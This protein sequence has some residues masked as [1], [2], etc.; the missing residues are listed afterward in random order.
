M[1]DYYYDEDGF[2]RFH[3]PYDTPGF[4][5]VLGA[6]MVFG[7]GLVGLSSFFYAAYLMFTRF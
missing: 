1:D 2:I 7:T 6:L 4:V 3:N 5:R